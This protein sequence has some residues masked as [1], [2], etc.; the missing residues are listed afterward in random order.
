MTFFKLNKLNNIYNYEFYKKR[1]R[2]F[3]IRKV[4]K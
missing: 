2:F 1:Y 4:I 3:V